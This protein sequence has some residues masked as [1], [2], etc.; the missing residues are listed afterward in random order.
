M[1]RFG[2]VM[3]AVDDEMTSLMKGVGRTTITNISVVP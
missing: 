1:T 3:A 2:D